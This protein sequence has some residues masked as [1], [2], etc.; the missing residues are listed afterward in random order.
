MTTSATPSPH[1]TRLTGP[2]RSL[3]LLF[4]P[5]ADG[6]LNDSGIRL[7][8]CR[9]HDLAHEEADGLDLARPVV[10]DRGRVRHQDL[11]YRRADDPRVRNLAETP[12]RDDGR[13]GI[14]RL[15]MGLE[16]LL[17]VGARDRSV[18]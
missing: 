16:D 8:S 4:E 12:A 2:M 9:L 15:D 3:L 13:C 7:A 14:A 17:G 5:F 6:S 1:S 18:L 11:V 10:G